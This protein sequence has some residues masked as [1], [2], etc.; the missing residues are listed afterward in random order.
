MNQIQEC[1]GHPADDATRYG[2]YYGSFVIRFTQDWHTRRL[3]FA[4]DETL[5]IHENKLA[6]A[7]AHEELEYDNS[8]IPPHV[9]EFVEHFP[10]IDD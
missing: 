10:R 1:G 2:A 4:K 6:E 5:V 7:M 8:P 9:Y 3:D